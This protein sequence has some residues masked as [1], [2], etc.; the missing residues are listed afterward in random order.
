MCIRDR[1]PKPEQLAA[2]EK[3]YRAFLQKNGLVEP[4]NQSVAG[5][6]LYLSGFGDRP[7]AVEIRYYRAQIL[8]F[9]LGRLEEAGDEF[10]A[11]GKTAPVG[12]FHKLS[13]IHISEPTRQAEISYA[14]F[15]L[16][17]KKKK[18]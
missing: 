9:K 11:V 2:W 6:Q 13:L 3:N 7:D 18:R 16:K 10:L 14:V 17:K 8:Y 15:C 12:K 5:Y 4:Y 1:D